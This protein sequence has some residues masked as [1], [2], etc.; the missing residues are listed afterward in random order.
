MP[1]DLKDPLGW[2]FS[3]LRKILLLRFSF[4]N[5]NFQL[6]LRTKK[7]GSPYHPAALDSAA[8]SINGVSSQGFVCGAIA[9]SLH[10]STHFTSKFDQV[11]I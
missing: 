7:G 5:L 4:H 6:E 10:S 8:D 3:S 11:C 1:R 9:L 2:R